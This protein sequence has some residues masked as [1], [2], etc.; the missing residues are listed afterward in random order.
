MKKWSKYLLSIW[1]PVVIMAVLNCLLWAYLR[2]D[3]G[4]SDVMK[5]S[6]KKGD[7]DA[8]LRLDC[9]DRGCTEKVVLRRWPFDT[10]V[11]VYEPAD[12]FPEMSWLSPA[13]LEIT[14]KEVS[15]IYSQKTE[16]H[17]VKITYKIDK[18]DDPYP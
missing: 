10:E 3:F 15:H 11:F 16:A 18:V 5:S 14:A 9:T 13:E 12:N 4:Y 7:F 8:V 17:G 1:T 6:P 2:I